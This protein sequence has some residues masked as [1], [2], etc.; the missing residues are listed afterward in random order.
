MRAAEMV[1]KLFIY[2]TVQVLDNSSHAH[3]DAWIKFLTDVAD[4]LHSAHFYVRLFYA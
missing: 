3:V 4:M 1:K 2:A